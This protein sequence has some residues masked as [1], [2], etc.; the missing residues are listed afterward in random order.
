MS[1]KIVYVPLEAD[2]IHHG[3]INVI[4]KASEI[5]EVIIG[6]YSDKAIANFGRSPTLSFEDRKIIAQNIRGVKEVVCQQDIDCS[7][8]IL[9]IKPDFLV[10]GD[11]WKHGH[12][13]KIR[14]KAIK[15]IKRTG[16]KLIELEYTKG[17]SSDLIK[18]RIEQGVKLRAVGVTPNQRL[19]KLSSLIKEENMVRILEAHNGLTGLI[20]ENAEV[21]GSEFHGLWA[22]S[23]T[24]STVRGKPDTE[25][26]DFSSR[27]ST[28]EEIMEVTTKPIIVDGDTGGPIEHF[29]YRVRTLERLGV[30][31][32]IIEDKTGLKRNSLFGTD[33]SQKQEDVEIFCEKI[34][35]GKSVQVTSDFMIISRVESLILGKGVEDAIY[36]A[37]EYINAG[38]DAVM[39]HSKEKDAKEIQEFCKKYNKLE[40]KKPLVL[41]PST[42]PQYREDELMKWGVK[43]VIYA[44]HLL[45]SA[46]PAMVDTAISILKNKRSKEASDG[47]CMPVKDIIRL[48]PEDY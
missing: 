34:R 12:L 23:L 45:R 25:V 33:V 35:K 42:Y 47:N 8:N 37:S 9:K 24:D 5:G 15:T 43:V 2:L 26:V 38:S 22:S 29:K 20:V 32:V 46:Y 27:F 31:A 36:R 28:I 13:S 21:E 6:L 18:E 1:K 7:D 41:V 4:T 17:I 14:E 44:N 48:I 3:H 10:H 40:N 30:S 16:T 19:R 11:N 39:I